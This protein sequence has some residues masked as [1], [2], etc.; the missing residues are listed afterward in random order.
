MG[1]RPQALSVKVLYPRILQCQSLQ[2]QTLHL[3]ALLPHARRGQAPHPQVWRSRAR[4]PQ[5]RC[6]QLRGL[7]QR[8][9]H[10]L[11]PTAV[12]VNPTRRCSMP[13]PQTQSHSC[14]HSCEHSCK[15]EAGSC[16]EAVV[17][18]TTPSCSPAGPPPAALPAVVLVG[19]DQAD[20]KSFERMRCPITLVRKLSSAL[21]FP[22]WGDTA[23]LNRAFPVLCEVIGEAIKRLA[24][25]IGEPI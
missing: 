12:P 20:E 10:A 24:Q 11:K 1:W 3:Q 16:Q 6:L 23:C 14:K 18:P 5:M 4:H 21:S 15:R 8:Q 13:S 17:A 25:L 9:C 2:F 19:G 22:A 7:Y